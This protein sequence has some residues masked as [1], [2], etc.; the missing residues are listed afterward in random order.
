M[1]NPAA[2]P[3]PMIE[4]DIIC[5]SFFLMAIRLPSM[6]RAIANSEPDKKQAKYAKLDFHSAHFVAKFGHD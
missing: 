5:L 4:G 3:S 2:S 1:N 6:V